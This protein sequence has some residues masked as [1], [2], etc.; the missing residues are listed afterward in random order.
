MV[1]S[2]GAGGRDQDLAHVLGQHLAQLD[3]PLVE[4]IDAVDEAFGGHPVLVQS[5]KLTSCLRREG[6]VEEQTERWSVSEELLVSAE[7]LRDSL[8]LQLFDGLSTSKSVRL[9]K[10][11]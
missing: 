4:G 6:T 1:G 11:V 2:L 8:L 3:A 9:R 5:Q 7:I 10:E